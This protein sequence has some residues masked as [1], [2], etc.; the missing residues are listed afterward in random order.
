VVP[1]LPGHMEAAVDVADFEHL[2]LEEDLLAF[3]RA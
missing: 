1:R 2:V 3:S